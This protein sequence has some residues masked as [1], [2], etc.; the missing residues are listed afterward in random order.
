MVDV[1]VD[2]LEDHCRYAN[3]HH[4][5]ALPRRIRIERAFALKRES[6]DRHDYFGTFVRPTRLGSFGI[7]L[8]VDVTMLPLAFQTILTLFGPVSAMITS[9]CPLTE[10]ARMPLADVLDFSTQMSL[11]RVVTF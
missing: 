2:R 9:G 8:N 6:E 1:L 4:A 11:T 7:A 10:I 5:W 3:K